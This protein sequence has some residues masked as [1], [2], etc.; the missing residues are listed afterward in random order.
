VGDRR[1]EIRAALAASR[2][3]R[4]VQAEHVDPNRI[5]KQD[6]S[7]VTAA[8]FASQAVVCS[9]LEQAPPDDPDTNGRRL[10][11][12]RGRTLEDNRGIGTTAGPIHGGVIEAVQRVRGAA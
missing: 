11:F 3:C 8:D 5:E 6:R 12:R 7:P 4:A 1:E 2:I 9:H 10:D